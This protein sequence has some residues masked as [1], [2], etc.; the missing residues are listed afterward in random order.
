LRRYFDGRLN[1][2][3]NLRCRPRHARAAVRIQIEQAR[4]RLRAFADWQAA[5]NAAGWRIVF[6]EQTESN[7]KLPWEVDGQPIDI[8]GR[9]DRIDYH[10]KE[11][12][13][14]ILDYK[15]SD[16]AKEPDKVHRHRGEWVDLQL[17]LYRHLYRAI[18]NLDIGDVRPD[19]VK[20]G[21]VHLPKDT[22]AVGDR[23]APWTSEE[24][25][26][27]DEC[28]RRV[29]RQLRAGT[30]WPPSP[31][32]PSFEDAFTAICQDRS[33]GRCFGEEESA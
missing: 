27:A 12:T 16:T 14:C 13:L 1:T 32:P 19:G 10:P 33:L 29:I 31:E 24:L 15:T 17:P 21:F 6:S 28:A 23:L 3:A 30:F 2:V 7:W 25:K 4:L 22:G 18:D 5:R 26:E 8:A 9:I 11:R 20:L